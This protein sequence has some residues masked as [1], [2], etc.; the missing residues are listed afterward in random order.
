LNRLLIGLI[1]AGLCVA[2][3]AWAAPPPLEDYGKL[4]AVEEMKV[5]PD[6]DLIAYVATVGD[7]RQVR[8][9]KVG[10]PPTLAVGVGALKVRGLAWLGDGHVLVQVSLAH[11]ADASS[12]NASVIEVIQSSIIN[13]ATGK[14]AAVFQGEAHIFPGTYDFYGYGEVGGK[15][16]A[17]FSGQPLEGSGSMAS[18]FHFAT[19]AMTLGFL[20]LYQVDL[21]TGHAAK[22]AGGS[23]IYRTRWIVTR[24]GGLAA[25]EEYE[26]KTGEWRLFAD[27]D[28]TKL[29]A[30]TVDPTGKYSLLGLGRTVDSSLVEMPANNGDWRFAEYA[31]KSGDPGVE[32]FADFPVGELIRDPKTH[33]LVGAISADHESVTLFDAKLQARFDAVRR[34]FKGEQVAF[35]SYS[36]DF[37]QIVVLTTGPGDSGT[38]FLVDLVSG[39]A[40]AVGWNYPTILQADVA[41]VRD[42]TYKAADGMALQGVLTL[43][44]GKPAKNL[45]LV[46]IPHG[47]P[48]ERDYVGFDWWAQAFASRG[49]A[50]FQPNFR[51]SDGFGRAFLEAGYGQWGRKMQTDISD[52]VAELAK[53]GIV[54]PKRACIV[55][56]SY[57][58]YAALAGVTL[59]QGLY[60]CAV[61]VG[62]VSNLND[63]LKWTDIQYG[64]QSESLRIDLLQLG[65][66]SIGDPAMVDISPQRQAA[67]A[68]AP[69]L[70]MFGHD[71]TVVNPQ[72]SRAMADALKAA[73]KPVEIVELPNE[74][75]WLSRASTRIAVV[76][77]SV[78]FV[79]KNNPP[80]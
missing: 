12:F 77:G 48:A 56:A 78:D 67:K 79:M 70:L 20:N 37:K 23:A 80:D 9:G 16:Y 46:V 6:G 69:I 60:R 47:G 35:V 39:K 62:G 53:Q 14:S 22:V 63:L 11:R 66:K 54:D 13:V 73:G 34:A 40:S 17:Y 8:I 75:H 57:G 76:K 52:G 38:Y 59:Q 3:Q 31:D 71:D 41:E 58:G 4:P 68:D 64:D 2:A 65:A 51:G 30:K 10:G 49:Y 28:D 42:V 72:Q 25:H 7:Q 18:D 15:G 33:V 74:D 43:P 27:P 5:S 29:I 61:S 32:L 19:G 24:D 1:A 55:G 45:P 44:P 26:T 36:S 21:D 50:V